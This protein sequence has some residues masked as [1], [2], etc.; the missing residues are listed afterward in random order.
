MY[1]DKVMKQKKLY[2]N[3]TRFTYD[4]TAFKGWRLSIS[5]KSKQFTCY[6]SDKEYGGESVALEAAI[7]MRDAIFED[8]AQGAGTPQRIFDKYK[9]RKLRTQKKARDLRKKETRAKAK[10]KLSN[11]EVK[12]A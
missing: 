9:A 8:L 7:E 1:T 11:K 3:L 6:F 2:K 10:K 5:R 12:A 4:K